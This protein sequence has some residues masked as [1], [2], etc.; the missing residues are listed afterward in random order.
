MTWRGPRLDVDGDLSLDDGGRME[1]LADPEDSDE[2]T[3][4]EIDTRLTFF[5]GENF[6]DVREGVPWFQEILVKGV[7]EARVK[8]IV[9]QVVASHPAVI[10][11]P[12]VTFELDRETRAAEI[13]WEA[14]TTEGRVILSSDFRP[15]IVL[16]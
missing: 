3:A 14:R 5:R 15:L 1:W 16:P 4:Q 7:D 10:D 2:A 13:V 11:V 8:A 6:L 9:R 12:T